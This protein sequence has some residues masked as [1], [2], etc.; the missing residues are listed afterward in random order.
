MQQWQ[1]LLIAG[2][3]TL[4]LIGFVKSFYE[5]AERKNT[6]GLTYVFRIY[7]A[8]VWADLV[9]FGLF[10]TFVSLI[11]L[12]L[13]NWYLFLLFV[14][15]FWLVRSIG[16]TIYWLGQQFSTLNKN[17]VNRFLM[18]KVFHNE[19]LWFVY[20]VFWQ[21]MTVF[22]AICTIYLTEVWLKSL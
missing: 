6:Y 13:N 21:C 20:Q 18:K 5:C 7:G 2:W 19:S 4:A 16:E 14:S 8:F 11:S 9:I 17:P 10:W 1:Q 3:G 15:I 22:F 12:L